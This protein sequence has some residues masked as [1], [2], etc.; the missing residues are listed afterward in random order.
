[1][2]NRLDFQPNVVCARVRSRENNKIGRGLGGGVS[3]GGGKGTGTG[4]G[5]RD[6]ESNVALC[7]TM[8]RQTKQNIN[9]AHNLLFYS[10]EYLSV[11][12]V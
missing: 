9:R 5:K 11:A 10:F 12:F 4:D 8:S 2:Y 7:R 3:G 1:M 6:E